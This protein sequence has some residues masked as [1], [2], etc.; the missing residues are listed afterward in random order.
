M[1]AKFVVKPGGEGQ[2][3]F[4]LMSEDGRKLLTS[5]MFPAKSSVFNGIEAVKQHAREGSRYEKVTSAE[6]KLYFR[7]CS[8]TKDILGVSE[9][10]EN[11]D[12]RDAALSKVMHGSAEASVVEEAAAKKTR[13][14]VTKTI[15]AK[16][17][18]KRTLRALSPEPVVIR[19]GSILQQ[20][21]EDDRR[22]LF[23]YLGELYEADLARFRGAI[24]MV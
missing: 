21:K 12:A 8:A 19:L 10:F 15:E 9:M 22:L 17:L 4:N 5:G 11:M 1:A 14:E 18:N 7:L 20:V 23:E 3:F 16:K 24:K 2:F 13:A 6:G